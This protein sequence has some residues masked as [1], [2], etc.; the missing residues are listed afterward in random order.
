MFPKFPNF[1]TLCSVIISSSVFLASASA[2]PIWINEI[3]YDNI[4]GDTGEFVEIAGAASTD[5]TGYSLELYNGSNGKKYGSTISILGSIT[6]SGNGF[7]F[8]VFNIV[9]F[10]VSGI[11]NGSPDGVALTNGTD[12]Q[13]LSYEGVFTATSGFANGKTSTSIGVEE[14]NT[15]IGFSLQLTGN[16]TTY[17]DFDWS[18]P[19]KAT[20]GETNSGQTFSVPD[21]VS[22]LS[23]LGM[24]CLLILSNARRRKF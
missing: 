12:V 9:D 7:G 19:Q 22:T 24:A 4:G 5:L 3:H 18:S 10:G 8:R 17:K 11:Q 1:S 2:L 21:S 6:D 13:F 15:P 16:G 14:S 20:S 23:L